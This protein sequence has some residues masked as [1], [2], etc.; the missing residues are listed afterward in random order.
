MPSTEVVNC[1]VPPAR[2]LEV[3]GERAMDWVTGFD[4]EFGAL[5]KP[6]QL[7][8]RTARIVTSAE[9]AARDQFVLVR[10]SRFAYRACFGVVPM[11]SCSPRTRETRLYLL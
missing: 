9:H 10:A 11:L 6:V 7:D 3:A 4:S 8:A 2:T 5:T 1:C